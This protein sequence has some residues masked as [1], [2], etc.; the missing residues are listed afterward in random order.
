MCCSDISRSV[1]RCSRLPRS[2]AV[3]LCLFSKHGDY[4]GPQTLAALPALIHVFIGAFLYW[5]Q[6]KNKLR[7]QNK[8]ALSHSL[9]FWDQTVRRAPGASSTGLRRWFRDGLAQPYLLRQSRLLTSAFHPLCFHI[10]LRRSKENRTKCW[11]AQKHKF[12]PSFMLWNVFHEARGVKNSPSFVST[13]L[14][15][16][17][18]SH[19]RILLQVTEAAGD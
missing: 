13:H 17:G 5:A 18:Q 7:F 4:I 16:A 14:C 15:E 19:R 2:P 11:H 8:W 9:F 10:S 12:V 3:L 6:N 1:P